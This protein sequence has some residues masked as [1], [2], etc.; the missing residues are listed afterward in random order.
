MTT[1]PSPANRFRAD[2]VL[3]ILT[4][5]TALTGRVLL[6]RLNGESAGEYA[7][8]VYEAP[9]V[10][11]AHD[12]GEDPRFTYANRTAQQLFERAWPAFIGLPSR[13]SAEPDDRDARQVLLERVLRDG[14]CDDYRGI[15]VAA[16]GRRFRINGAT[17][18]NVMDDTGAR[19][20]Q[21]ATFAQWVPYAH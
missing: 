18:W 11:L 3:P 5:Y 20:G 19:I 4:S 16:S 17:L 1:A 6:T 12:G 13:Y 14:Y 8:R 15:R 21:A 9:F 7:L 10:L 2:R